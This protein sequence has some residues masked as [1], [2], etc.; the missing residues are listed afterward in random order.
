MNVVDVQPS[1]N[2]V[3]RVK[4]M[5]I[6]PK[7]EWEVIDVE[8][9]E[10]S[11]LI[12]GYLL[13]LAGLSAAAAFVGTAIVGQTVP[14]VGYIRTPFMAALGVAILALCLTVVG[15][16]ILSVI[17]NALAPTFAGQKDS[18]QAMKV[19]VYSY[20]PALVAGLAQVLPFGSSIIGILGGLYGIYLMYLGLP[21]LMK[22]PADKAVAYTA[23]T[24][25]CAIVVN[26]VLFAVSAA[27]TATTVGIGASGAGIFGGGPFG[28]APAS[29][30]VTFDPDSPLGKL[31]QLGKGLEESGRKIEA[32]ERSGDQGAQVAAAV[33]GL[34]ALLGG[35]TRVD[36]VDIA[37][38][39]TFVPDTFAGMPR[40]SSS[41]EKTGF[42]VM[43]SRAEGTYSDGGSKQV[44]LEVLDTGGVAGLMGLASWM[45]VQEEKESDDGYER[46]QKVNGRLVHEK[47][48]KQGSNEFSVVIGERFMVSAKGR[49]L[50]VS[51]LKSAVAGLD[52]AGLEGLKAAAVEK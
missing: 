46:T 13:P 40:R 10:T 20:T 38:L 28:G 25:V 30:T 23:T 47:M 36:P 31:E 8:R 43:V 1:S 3:E 37:Q 2:L 16:L 5:L 19:A 9:T 17:V 33:E 42:G 45:G 39:K 34:G 49:G 41:A 35:G 6:S 26:V 32:A 44:T 7:S 50:D 18:S 14:L 11:S 4:R 52:L 21:R 29:A 51:E 15:V 12:G 48:S 27:V 22:S 24:V